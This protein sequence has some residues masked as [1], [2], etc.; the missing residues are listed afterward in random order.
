MQACENAVIV[1]SIPRLAELGWAAVGVIS[2][3]LLLEA[4]RTGLDESAAEAARREMQDVGR[5][6][7][8]LIQVKIDH[9]PSSLR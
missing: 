3:A 2:D 8:I 5:G 7:G 9:A 4:H 1:A 6:L